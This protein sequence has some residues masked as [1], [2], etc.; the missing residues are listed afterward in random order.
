MD[1]GDF[2]C[3]LPGAC[4]ASTKPTTKVATARQGRRQGGKPAIR[5]VVP[6]RNRWILAFIT[7]TGGP[8]SHNAHDG[9]GRPAG[10]RIEPADIALR[11]GAGFRSES[12]AKKKP[13]PAQAGK[14]EWEG[15]L[16]GLRIRTCS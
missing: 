8:A 9:R 14:G 16:S 7:D 6:A 13:L 5:F 1:A 2:S 10:H 15:I 3:V 12:R 11:L 4:H